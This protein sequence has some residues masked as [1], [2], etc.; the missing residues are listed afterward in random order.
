MNTDAVIANNLFLT[1]TDQITSDEAAATT[2]GA[3]GECALSCSES[4]PGL[5]PP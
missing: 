3:G 1:G 4:D 2:P 5:V